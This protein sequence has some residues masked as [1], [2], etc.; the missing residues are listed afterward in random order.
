MEGLMMPTEDKQQIEDLTAYIDKKSVEGFNVAKAYP[1]DNALFNKTEVSFTKSD[2]DPQ[3]LINLSFTS[4]AKIKF[5]E[6]RGTSNTKARPKTI[7]IFKNKVTAD[8]DECENDEPTQEITLK[9]ADYSG[10]TELKFVKFQSVTSLTIFI[11]DNCGADTTE[12][13]SLTFYGLRSGDM[14]VKQLKKVGEDE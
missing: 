1:I 4:P 3:I 12:F 7:K 6:L 8:F 2:S 10:K 9:E 11:Q 5:F 13:S 14:D